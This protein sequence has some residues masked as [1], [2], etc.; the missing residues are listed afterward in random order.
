MAL[1]WMVPKSLLV[2]GLR[3]LSLSLSNPHHQQQ[4]HGLGA[5]FRF[6]IQFDRSTCPCVSDDSFCLLFFLSAVAVAVAVVVVVVVVVGQGSDG[7]PG[8]Q[9]RRQGRQ[10]QQGRH[11]PAHHRQQGQSTGRSPETAGRRKKKNTH[12]C[13]CRCCSTLPL[14]SPFWL[15]VF[16]FVQWSGLI[17][18]WC[19]FRV[20][21][22]RGVSAVLRAL[23][24]LLRTFNTCLCGAL[25]F[26]PTSFAGVCRGHRGRRDGISTPWHQRRASFA[27]PR[28]LTGKRVCFLLCKYR[29]FSIVLIFLGA[30]FCVGNLLSSVVTRLVQSD[31]FARASPPRNLSRCIPVG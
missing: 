19:V 21:C 8:S 3:C 27:L 4:K 15:P 16:F 29:L 10:G 25:P 31:R 18:F 7:R 11:V 20:S 17:F 24:S 30:G 9:A 2:L 28:R 13:L 5:L 23:L 1:P 12:C 6:I 14:P 22:C 26:L